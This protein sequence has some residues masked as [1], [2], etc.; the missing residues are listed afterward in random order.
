MGHSQRT[1]R[2]FRRIAGVVA[3][4][5][6][7]TLLAGACGA[8]SSGEPTDSVTIAYQPGLGY[9]P[10]LI[11]KQ[12]KWIENKVPNV[13]IT[14]Q[15]LD[16][17]SAIRDGVISGDIHVA[18]GGTG[19][20]LVGYD[21]GVGW[22]VLMALDNM[23][24]MLMAK[25]PAITSLEDVEGK[26]QIAMP[27][28]DSIQ[29]VVLRKGAA[30]QLGDPKSLDSQIVALGHPDG[31]QALLAGQLDAHLTSPPFQGQEAEAGAHPILDSYDMFGEHTF[32]SLYATT[33]FVEANPEFV[34]AL[35]TSTSRGIQMLNENPEQAAKILSE[36]SGGEESPS[37]LAA[38][39]TADDVEFTAKPQGFGKFAEFMAEIGM[40]KETPDT[41]E[42]FFDNQ[43]TRGGS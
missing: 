35:T 34:D 22:K 27:A 29:S 41:E 25:D 43:Y 20:F 40:I 17:G 38:Q 2:G 32:N 31:L 4:M 13:E 12:E 36:E 15:E 6:A 30:E 19:P 1:R 11:A 37:D 26:G 39:A 42:L 18:A 14:W 8:S 23:K 3:A 5:S 28:P 24:L 21:G 33:E 7:M 9:A 16:S 10:L